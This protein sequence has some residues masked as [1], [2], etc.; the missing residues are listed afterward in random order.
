MIDKDHLPYGCF[1]ILLYR[2]KRVV[3]ILCRDKLKNIR[4]MAKI[5]K[6]R[7]YI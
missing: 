2:K 6:A 5:E 3:S 7:G 4:E 1:G